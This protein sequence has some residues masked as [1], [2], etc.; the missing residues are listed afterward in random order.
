[1]ADGLAR[2]EQLFAVTEHYLVAAY[3]FTG[4]PAAIRIIRKKD[5]AVMN[6]QKLQGTNFELFQLGDSI[7]VEHWYDIGRTLYQMQGF[8]GPPSWCGAR[9]STHRPRTPRASLRRRDRRPTPPSRSRQNSCGERSRGSGRSSAT[10]AD[11][12]VGYVRPASNT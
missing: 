3:G 5:G 4:E 7:A 8:D 1:M 9:Q 12:I 11:A 6:T 2:V 10:I